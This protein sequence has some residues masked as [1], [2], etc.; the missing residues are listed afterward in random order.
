ML[1]ATFPCT[2]KSFIVSSSLSLSSHRLEMKKTKLFLGIFV[3]CIYI[4]HSSVDELLLLTYKVQS[5]GLIKIDVFKNNVII[6]NNAYMYLRCMRWLVRK[7][8]CFTN[9]VNLCIFQDAAVKKD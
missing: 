9:A 2:A 7:L 6:N 5:E 3:C 8:V 4:D 1:P